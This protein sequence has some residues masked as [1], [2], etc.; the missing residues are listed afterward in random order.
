MHCVS[1][2]I[3]FIHFP[4]VAVHREVQLSLFGFALCQLTG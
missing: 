2:V 1:F 4:P 3:V